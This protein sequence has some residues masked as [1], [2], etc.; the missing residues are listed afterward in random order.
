MTQGPDFAIK[1]TLTGAKVVLRPFREDDVPAMCSILL[2]PEAR[3]LTGSVHDEAQAHA[4]IEPDRDHVTGL[5]GMARGLLARAIDTDM[6]GLDQ[7]GRAGAGFHH[8]RM[9]QP[10]IE[11]LALQATPFWGWID[12]A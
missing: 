1:P 7:R 11:T 9:P 3:V 12:R 4:A 2:D 5:D 10:F 6:A 8:P